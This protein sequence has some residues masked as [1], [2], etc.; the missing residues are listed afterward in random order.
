MEKSRIFKLAIYVLT[1]V[2]GLS[3][4]AA[5]V[6]VPAQSKAN[7]REVK[8]PDAEKA[9]DPVAQPTPPSATAASEEGEKAG[10]K[11]PV[12]KNGR[13]ESASSAEDSNA[14]DPQKKNQSPKMLPTSAAVSAAMRLTDHHCWRIISTASPRQLGAQLAPKVRENRAVAGDVVAGHSG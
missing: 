8:K 7:K 4:A 9:Q 1:V 10:T 5:A 14:R 11:T 2:F 3:A 6:A 13:P 12:K